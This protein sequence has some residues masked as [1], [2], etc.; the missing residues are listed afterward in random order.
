M[1]LS[2]TDTGSGISADA[3]LVVAVVIL[4]AG[5]RLGRR[6]IQTL[7]DTAPEGASARISDIAAATGSI[8]S[9]ERVRVR[10]VGPTMFA[11]VLVTISHAAARPRWR[12][13]RRSRARFPRS[14][15]RGRRDRRVARSTTSVLERDHGD[16]PQP[17]AR[18]APRDH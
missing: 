13:R 3:A 2:I 9:V 15:G 14:T 8:V 10:S 4:I 1:A 18:R 17:C 7:T 16:C 12:S 6:T 11:D 5:W